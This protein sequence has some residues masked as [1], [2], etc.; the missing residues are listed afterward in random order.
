MSQPLNQA[1]AISFLRAH[2]SASEQS[3]LRA[4]LAGTPATA[5][6]AA[7]I[8]TGQRSDGGWAPFWAVDY[9]AVD[10]T[11][12]RLAQAEQGGISLDHEAIQR[13]VQFLCSRQRPDG[14]WTSEDG[15]AADA[16]TTLEA[17][18]ALRLRGQ[19]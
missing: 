3:R 1:K 10:A 13:A 16:H 15:F 5:E 8:L 6:A 11:C 19:W 9:R 14:G 18:R 7:I 2:G 4:L 17:L 12:F